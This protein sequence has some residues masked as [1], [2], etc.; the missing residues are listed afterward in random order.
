MQEKPQKVTASIPGPVPSTGKV[1][2][3]FSGSPEYCKMAPVTLED[4]AT[5]LS[6]ISRKLSF[7]TMEEALGSPIL[8]A[9]ADLQNDNHKPSEKATYMAES[10]AGAFDAKLSPSIAQVY[11]IT[12]NVLLTFLLYS[13]DKGKQKAPSFSQASDI[14]DVLSN[15]SINPSEE[16]LPGPPVLTTSIAVGTIHPQIDAVPQSVED[17]TDEVDFLQSEEY[18]MT[19]KTKSSGRFM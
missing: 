12:L 5:K 18:R 2:P 4:K 10:V 14:E 17:G 13:I 9:A 1:S 16:A 15:A 3:P 6:S 19:L 11:S 7:G 8:A